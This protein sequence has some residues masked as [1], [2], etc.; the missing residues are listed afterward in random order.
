MHEL[1][2]AKKGK[3]EIAKLITFDEE[4]IQLM[5]DTVARGATDN[6]F[7]LFMHLAQSYGLDDMLLAFRWARDNAER[8]GAPKGRAAV[9]GDSMGG[10]FAAVVAQETKRLNAPALAN[11][12]NDGGCL[13]AADIARN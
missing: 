8:F 4:Q 13:Q 3:A 1:P 12:K 6:E 10:N 7:K 11:L 2:A 5:K 9:G